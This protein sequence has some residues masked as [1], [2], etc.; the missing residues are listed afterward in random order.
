ME[1]TI[2]YA[3]DSSYHEGFNDARKQIAEKIEEAIDSMMP[4]VD[5][6]DHIVY[7]TLMWAYKVASGLE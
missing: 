5:K 6:T 1:K 7:N 2:K 3:L 4:P